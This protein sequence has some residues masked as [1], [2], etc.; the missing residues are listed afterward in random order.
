VTYL[1]R[2][3]S[4]RTHS[5]I[6][7]SAVRAPRI[8]WRVGPGVVVQ[9]STDGGATWVAQQTGA[10][11]ALTAGSAPAPDVLWLV[12]RGGVVLRTTDRGRQW[13]RVPFPE[14]V[15]LTAITATSARNATVVVA[16]GR[17]FVTDDGGVTWIPVR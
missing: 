16:E 14:T 15:D 2:P 17:P 4:F 12:G 6:A 7:P 11:S 10:P 3:S 1:Y 8:R 9:H 5:R 13:Q